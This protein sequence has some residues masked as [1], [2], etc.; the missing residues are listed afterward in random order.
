[1]CKA[2]S[3]FYGEGKDAKIYAKY[4]AQFPKINLFTIDQLFGGWTKAQK[5]HFDDGGEFDKLYGKK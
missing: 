2:H 1:M 3:L 5:T 4:Q